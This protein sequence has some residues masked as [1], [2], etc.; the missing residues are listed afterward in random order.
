MDALVDHVELIV[1][2]RGNHFLLQ[3]SSTADCPTIERNH[4]IDWHEIVLG[5]EAGEIAQKK[6]RGIADAAIRIRSALQN[7]VGDAHF[8]GV[9]GGRDPQTQHIRAQTLHDLLRRHDVAERFRHLATL[10]IDR[11]AVREH[12]LVGC[13]LV[14]GLGHQERRVEPAAMLIGPFEIQ[15]NRARN[16][17]SCRCDALERETRIGPHVHDIVYF[18]VVD[19][20]LADQLFGLQRKPSLNAA[21]LDAISHLVDEFERARMQLTGDFVDEERDRHTP[22]SLTRDTPVRSVLD[23]ARDALLTPRRRPCHLLDV[24]ERMST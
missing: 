11:E 12:A 7:L 3:R 15:I 24:I 1:S 21:L 22:G 17:R 23:H 10:I 6:A 2:I 5:I 18:V 16:L 19:R 8:I 14:Q 9:V 13:T 20:F 4:L